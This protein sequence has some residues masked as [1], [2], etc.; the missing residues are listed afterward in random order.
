M[1][2]VPAATRALRVL[3]DEVVPNTVGRLPGAQAPVTVVV[4]FG[5]GAGNDVA[6]RIAKAQSERK[7]A[8]IAPGSGAVAT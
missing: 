5:P 3:R 1:S 8:L 6:A 7:P 2:Q 4:N